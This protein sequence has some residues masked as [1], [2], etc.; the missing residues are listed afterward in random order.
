M[1]VQANPFL[2]VK[3]FV[4]VN[5]LVLVLFVPVN[6]S[7]IVMLVQ[8]ILLVLTTFVQVKP[9]VLEIFV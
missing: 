3:P 6:P 1:F 7:V 9:S 4:H 5:L 2:L 8:V